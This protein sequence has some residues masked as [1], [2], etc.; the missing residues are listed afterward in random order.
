MDAFACCVCK[1]ERVPYCVC[2]EGHT[3]CRECA[4]ELASRKAACPLC[5]G[6]LLDA[7]VRNLFALQ[8]AR[9]DR[10]CEACP[11]CDGLTPRAEA[12]AHAK[13]CKA[14][15]PDLACERCGAHETAFAKC[16]CRDCDYGC[17]EYV[18]PRDVVAHNATC[19]DRPVFCTNAGCTEEVTYRRL[20]HHV[21]AWCPMRM[22]TCSAEG[23]GARMTDGALHEHKRSECAFNFVSCS[24]GQRVLVRDMPTHRAFQCPLWITACNNNAHRGCTVRV[25]ALLQNLHAKTCAFRMEACA[26]CGRFV[27][28][29]TMREHAVGCDGRFHRITRVNADAYF[30][31]NGDRPRT[32]A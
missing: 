31:V 17:G 32:F 24:C 22:V 9:D 28:L 21:D 18:L 2:A 6:K 10:G 23:C 13:A 26:S 1:L 12:A 15:L 16:A 19:P 4:R 14:Q 27:S 5:R 30:R 25:S 11:R 7:P 29:A 8:V 20:A 3:A